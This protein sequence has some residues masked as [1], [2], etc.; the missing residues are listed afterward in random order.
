MLFRFLTVPHPSLEAMT[1]TVVF[2]AQGRLTLVDQPAN[3]QL[4]DAL[5][6]TDRAGSIPI[7]AYAGRLPLPP[8]HCSARGVFP[9]G[10]GM[11]ALTRLA[12]S[13]MVPDQLVLT[14]WFDI[15]PSEARLAATLAAGGT[16]AD[17]AAATGVTIKT[18]RAFTERVLLGDE[19]LRGLEEARLAVCA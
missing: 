1:N 8:P 7:R 16:I 2:A 6:C 10:H 11:L 5:H 4:A 18:A 14:G 17:A 9:G 12:S 3:A 15:T 13:A 19:R